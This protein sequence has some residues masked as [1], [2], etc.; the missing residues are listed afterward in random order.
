MNVQIGR[1]SRIVLRASPYLVYR[2]SVYGVICAG[3][4]LLVLLRALIW[5]V[6]G[7]GAAAVML[8]IALATGGLV[9]AYSANM[10]CICRALDVSLSSGRLWSEAGC[11]RESARRKGKREGQGVLHRNQRPVTDRPD[12]HRD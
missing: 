1:A 7:G 10:C 3:A 11:L 2:A 5:H 4:A 8:I 6:C 12:D 9:R